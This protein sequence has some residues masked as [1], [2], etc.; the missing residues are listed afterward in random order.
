MYRLA[1]NVGAGGLRIYSDESYKVDSKLELDLLL[2]DS[3]SVKCLAR[4]V[5]VKQL[6]GGAPAKYDIGLKFL[7]VPEHARVKLSSVLEAD[8]E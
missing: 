1:V 2:P 4:V 7:Q 3:H 8:E 6:D 5:W